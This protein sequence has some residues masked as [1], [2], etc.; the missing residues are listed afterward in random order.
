M[1]AL[2]AV[3]IG[4][5]ASSSPATARAAVTMAAS[6][7]LGVGSFD[8][9]VAGTASIFGQSLTLNGAGS[10]DGAQPVVS[11]TT[12]IE[13]GTGLSMTVHE[14]MVD[15]TLYVGGSLLDSVLPKG[16]SWVSVPLSSLGDVG[17]SVGGVTSG[18]PTGVLKILATPSSGATVTDLGSSTI[19]AVT[20][21]RYRVEL[22][23]SAIRQ[24]I[25]AS[26]LSASLKASATSMIQ[27]GNEVVTLAID[28]QHH[29][30]RMN[31]TMS[32]SPVSGVS[33][34]ANVTM[35]L[36]NFG[37]A[38]HVSAPPASTVTDLGALAPLGSVRSLGSEILSR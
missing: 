11:S 36:T 23:P 8:F 35:D 25:E 12:S 30:R 38:V 28:G 3:L 20:V 26:K 9:T 37:T 24:R 31:L 32:V 4:V 17:Q 27:S 2:G 22:T 16:A 10:A 34:A 33:V 7:S 21:E 29:V 5:V 13:G 15:G 1:L 6:S 19:D 18:D 14:I